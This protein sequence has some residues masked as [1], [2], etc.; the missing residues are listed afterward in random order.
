M[1]VI[2]DYEKVGKVRKVNSNRG[3]EQVY[4]DVRSIVQE[5]CV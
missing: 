1:P 2:A 5:Y 3:P 4:S